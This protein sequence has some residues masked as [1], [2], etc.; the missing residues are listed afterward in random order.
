[1][2]HRATAATNIEDALD[3]ARTGDTVLA[4]NGGIGAREDA[5]FCLNTDTRSGNYQRR[6]YRVVVP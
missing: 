2:R 4:T 3:V 6:Y 1:M 5:E